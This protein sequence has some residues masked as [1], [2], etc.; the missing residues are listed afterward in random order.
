MLAYV[1]SGQYDRDRAAVGRQQDHQMAKIDKRLRDLLRS[2]NLADKITAML[3]DDWDANGGVA[4]M[5]CGYLPGKAEIRQ[6]KRAHLLCRDDD[7]KWEW[8]AL[9]A[10]K[11]AKFVEATESL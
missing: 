5:G 7:S 4:T 11:I 9:M 8:C 1:R 2:P 3:F 6:A 10:N